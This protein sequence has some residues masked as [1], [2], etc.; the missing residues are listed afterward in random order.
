MDW[1]RFLLYNALGAALWVGFWGTLFYE[2]GR[3]ASRYRHAFQHAQVCALGGAVLAAAATIL[4][5][6]LKHRGKRAT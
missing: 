2:L 6:V 3:G 1:P 4:Y 5:W